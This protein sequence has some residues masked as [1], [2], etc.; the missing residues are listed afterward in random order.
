MRFHNYV[1]KYSKYKYQPKYEHL[2]LILP[3]IIRRGPRI[4]SDFWWFVRSNSV[5]NFVHFDHSNL[6]AIELLVV[7]TR[8]D[9]DT[10]PLAIQKGVDSSCNL[11]RVVSI[12]VPQNEVEE[13]SKTL[14]T[15]DPRIRR[16]TT[17]I[18]ETSII[19]AHS[20]ELIR[21]YTGMNY[22]WY[23]QQFL[24]IGFCLEST[25]AG[26]LV[27][28]ADTLILRRICWLDSQGNQPLVLAITKFQP[29]FDFLRCLKITNRNPKCSFV[30]HHMMYQPRILNSILSYWGRADFDAFVEFILHEM[31]K[32]K[33]TSIS[34][35]YELYGQFLR[36]KYPHK[37]VFQ[38]FCNSSKPRI[39]SI[40]GIHALNE[41]EK[42][43]RDYNSISLHSWIKN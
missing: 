13:C 41:Y 10:L 16:I 29:Y 11:I 37:V 30:T 38:R 17:V 14:R 21:K 42:L 4:V 12:V 18:S 43:S 6:P 5:A 2:L 8:K 28:D 25:S 3:S 39:S 35:D 26:I 22:G 20:R 36:E 32:Y 34:I 40:G 7:A 9:F 23:L 24:K 27:I 15:L 31:N 1:E 33:I 19:S